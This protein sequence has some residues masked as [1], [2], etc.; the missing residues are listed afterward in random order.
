MKKKIGV[1]LALLVLAI[2]SFVFASDDKLDIK[3][4]FIYPNGDVKEQDCNSTYGSVDFTEDALSICN[5][6]LFMVEDVLPDRLTM[7]QENMLDIA[8]Q[9]IDSYNL[10]NDMNEIKQAN[11]ILKHIVDEMLKR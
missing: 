6:L 5:D 8:Q 4:F 11:I 2:S 9:H 1:V 10:S 7:R 3:V